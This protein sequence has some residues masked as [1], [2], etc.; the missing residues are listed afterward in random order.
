M[1]VNCGKRKKMV[2]GGR[3]RQGKFG[4]IYLVRGLLFCPELWAIGTGLAMGRKL[5]KVVRNNKNG[6][7]LLIEYYYFSEVLYDS[8]LT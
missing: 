3:R 5:R 4:E 8:I 2:L 1:C 6:L 7:L